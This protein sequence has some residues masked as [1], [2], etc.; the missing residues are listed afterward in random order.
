MVYNF[1][2][3]SAAW[4]VT[5]WIDGLASFLAGAVA[6]RAQWSTAGHVALQF[7]HFRETSRTKGGA[8]VVSMMGEPVVVFVFAPPNFAFNE[9]SVK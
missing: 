5:I 2:A 6:S 4:S 1:S 3:R 8:I 9:I 7:R